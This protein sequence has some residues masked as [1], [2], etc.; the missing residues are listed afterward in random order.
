MSAVRTVSSR[1]NW[2]CPRRWLRWCANQ[3]DAQ[4]TDG[5]R[6]PVAASLLQFALRGSRRQAGVQ[7]TSRHR[8]TAPRS[9][10]RH[11]RWPS[12]GGRQQREFDGRHGAFDLTGASAS[13][14][15][16]AWRRRR[17][18]RRRRARRCHPLRVPSRR[19]GRTPSRRTTHPAR[20]PWREQ[21]ATQATGRATPSGRAA[22]RQGSHP[23]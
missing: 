23:K 21:A 12:D 15:L 10:G 13:M 2:P 5:C 17:R 7:P 18:N 19:C 16:P 1:C 4:R 22:P 9:G 14:R 3:V 20:A 8:T 6:Q 11:P